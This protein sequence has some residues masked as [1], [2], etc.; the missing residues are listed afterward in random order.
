MAQDWEPLP[1]EPEKFAQNYPDDESFLT[2][3]KAAQ[4]IALQTAPRQADESPLDA[5]QRVEQGFDT[6]KTQI[7]EQLEAS[8]RMERAM[9]KAMFLRQQESEIKAQYQPGINATPD[10]DMKVGGQFARDEALRLLEQNIGNNPELKDETARL[11]NKQ[12]ERREAISHAIGEVQDECLKKHGLDKVEPAPQITPP[13]PAGAGA[14]DT[15]PLGSDEF[16][17]ALQREKAEIETMRRNEMLLP[18]DFKLN[19]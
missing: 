11:V 3:V 12:A 15:A 16:K 6:L 2:A 7:E 5:R 10:L 19:R 1:Y 4:E 17:A 8:H 14:L 13:Q 9:F 18:R